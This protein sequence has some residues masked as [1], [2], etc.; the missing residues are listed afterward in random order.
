MT[1]ASLGVD[2]A[3]FD[4]KQ[5]ASVRPI[6]FIQAI[7]DGIFSPSLVVNAVL[8]LEF[9]LLRRVIFIVFFTV[10]VVYTSGLEA[11]I[12]DQPF[13]EISVASATIFLDQ[14]D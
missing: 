11:K 8:Q 3:G 9:R 5:P 2:H 12:A 1:N 7:G 13:P 4:A 14:F 6:F 10:S